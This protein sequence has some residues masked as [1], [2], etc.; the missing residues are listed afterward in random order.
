MSRL[1]LVFTLLAAPSFVTSEDV[2]CQ[3]QDLIN[4]RFTCAGTKFDLSTLGSGL[5]S[6]FLFLPRCLA[7]RRAGRFFLLLFPLPKNR[8]S[9]FASLSTNAAMRA[10]PTFPV[11][12]YRRKCTTLKF[13]MADCQLAWR[14]LAVF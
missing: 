8:V 13:W 6:L 14:G 11:Q 5:V 2:I 12:E 7:T 10:I 3:I 4:F 9:F 1:W